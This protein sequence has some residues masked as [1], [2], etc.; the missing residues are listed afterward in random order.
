MFECSFSLIQGTPISAYTKIKT[1]NSNDDEIDLIL[2]SMLLRSPL[3]SFP[4]GQLGYTLPGKNKMMAM[5]LP[6]RKMLKCAV[7]NSKSRRCRLEVAMM[8]VSQ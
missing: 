3:T 1:N 5:R 8:P 4:H 7:V 2:W 6:Y